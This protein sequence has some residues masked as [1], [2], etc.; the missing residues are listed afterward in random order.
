MSTC[1]P[2]YSSA[3]HHVGFLVA[4]LGA[5]VYGAYPLMIGWLCTCETSTP[6]LSTR[7]FIRQMKDMEYTQ[8]LL[9][10]LGTFTDGTSV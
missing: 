4:A 7:W 1:V 6:F 9:V 3:A 2:P 5:Y 10:G 8:P